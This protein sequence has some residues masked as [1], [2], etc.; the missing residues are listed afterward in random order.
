MKM[1]TIAAAL[2]L[3]LIPIC[4]ARAGEERYPRMGPK[5]MAGMTQILVA[6]SDL[7]KIQ[8]A[9]ALGEARVGGVEF[10]ADYDA[11]LIARIKTARQ[12]ALAELRKMLAGDY[13]PARASAIYALGRSQDPGMAGP[14]AGLLRDKDWLVRAQVCRAL[15]ELGAAEFTNKLP[16]DDE[17]PQVR[18]EALAALAKL[19]GDGAALAAEKRFA[20]EKDACVRAA[21]LR[22]L[23]ALGCRTPA[24]ATRLAALNDSDPEVLA[25]GLRLAAGATTADAEVV[26]AAKKLAKHDSPPVRCACAGVLVAAGD[27]SRETLKELLQDSDQAVRRDTCLALGKTGAAWAMPLLTAEWRDELR[28][29]R[30]AA[31]AA[32]AERAAGNDARRAEVEQA[33]VEATRGENGAAAREGLWLLGELHSKAGFPA[34]LALAKE[35]PGQIEAE[36]QAALVLR[37]VWM[38]KYQPGGEL[39]VKFFNS[40]TPALRVHAA[41]A[42]LALQYRQAE[43][44][45]A[46]KLQE[47]KPVEMQK[48]WVYA[49]PERDFALQALAE[50]ADETALA[51]LTSICCSRDP[52]EKEENAGLACE[53]IVKADYKA[54]V[55]KF[56][57]AMRLPDFAQSERGAL[58]AETV[59]K[60]AGTSTNFQPRKTRPQFD[61]FFL[62][63]EE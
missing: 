51:A 13:A 41:N 12:A 37:V 6:E 46:A 47:T 38:A 9:T 28:P 15:A 61:R 18:I 32:L 53:A 14:A 29:V 34:I 19:G 58:L 48:I 57:A 43:G 31:S 1:R 22:C 30:R 62:N 33:A 49:G 55:G 45:L 2:L 63:V 36:A 59:A 23:R 35:A 7:D 54:A 21:C 11:D 44:M 60:L 39:A 40:R 16:L 3:G 4:A 24:K 27:G 25:E 8:A 50:F 56:T 26:A 42:I 5:T 10:P 17:N 20:A 52:L